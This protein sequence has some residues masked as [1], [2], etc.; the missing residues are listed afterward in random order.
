MPE[1]LK[2]ARARR[3]QGRSFSLSGLKTLGSPLIDGIFLVQ[4]IDASQT[5]CAL[6]W[7][8]RNQKL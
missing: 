7:T 2:T 6:N 5:N 3:E 4:K 1:L 8:A